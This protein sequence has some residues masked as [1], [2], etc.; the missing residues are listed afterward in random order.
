V[1]QPPRWYNFPL[2][3]Q[4]LRSRRNVSPPKDQ[5]SQV[6]YGRA[7]LPD[8]NRWNVVSD[9]YIIL[10][11]LDTDGPRAERWAKVFR[12]LQSDGD[13]LDAQHLLESEDLALQAEAQAFREPASEYYE[14]TVESR[15]LV[16]RCPV[17][18]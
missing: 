10:S 16:G 4:W 7:D 8:E 11:A 3:W 18:P 17:C 13:L 12:E 9:S 6:A 14:R 1:P 15:R 2:L 5:Q